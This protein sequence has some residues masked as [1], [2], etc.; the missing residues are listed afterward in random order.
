MKSR[1]RKINIVNTIIAITIMVVAILA[2][3]FQ[4]N[5]VKLR[6]YI[7][8]K[9]I[10]GEKSEYLK[11]IA[12]DN[13]YLAGRRNDPGVFKVFRYLLLN[14][15]PDLRIA[16][17]EI[18][19]EMKDKESVPDLIYISKN[20]DSIACYCALWS[21][22]RIGTPEAKK[23]LIN[24]AKN[25]TDRTLRK[26]AIRALSKIDD[27]DIETA[28]I[29][30]IDD[31]SEIVRSE[32]IESL[33]DRKSKAALSVIIQRLS[34]RSSLVRSASV[35]A[36]SEIND[37]RAIIP[38]MRYI[39]REEQKNNYIRKTAIFSLVEYDH[40]DRITAFLNKLSKDKDPDIRNTAI[41]ALRKIK[42]KSMK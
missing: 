8:L 3:A 23:Y 21:L 6:A 1:H 41:A 15:D 40:D 13:I 32:A 17:T 30:C 28:L 18:L 33:G 24:T 27:A 9:E 5:Y 25:G 16:A 22:G 36:L 4:N 34:D 37:D 31:N 12:M 20:D 26:E 29:K 10:S 11:K 42:D 39:V 7:V 2:I 14:N 19:G 35:D 38:L